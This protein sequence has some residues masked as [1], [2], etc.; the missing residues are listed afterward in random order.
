MIEFCDEIDGPGDHL[1]VAFAGIRQRLG[2]VPFEFN[3]SLGKTDAK[4]LFVRDV[5]RLWYQYDMGTINQ[6]VRQIRDTAAAVGATRLSCVGNS[7]GGFGALMFGAM[8]VAD[9]IL[10]FAPQ[11]TILPR[12]MV[13]MGD[14]RWHDYRANIK[15]HTLPD[16]NALSDVKARVTIHYGD[17]DALDAAHAGHLSWR[18]ERISHAGCGHNVAKMLRERGKLFA[19]IRTALFE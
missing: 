5:D 19:A 14:D 4:V 3:S 17:E 1:V 2:G 9:A 16:L 15:V 18:A 8:C 6:A 7:M 10:A 12:H 11:T 13:A